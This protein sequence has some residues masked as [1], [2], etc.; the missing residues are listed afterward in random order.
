[1]C[2]YMYGHVYYDILEH[3][4]ELIRHYQTSNMDFYNHT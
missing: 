1:M 2:D 3:Y 4:S